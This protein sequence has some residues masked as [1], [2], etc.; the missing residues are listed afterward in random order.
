MQVEIPAPTKPIDGM[1]MKFKTRLTAKPIPSEIK[2]NNFYY[3][4][5]DKL[6]KMKP[7]N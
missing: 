4:Q 6:N 2:N 1:S 5:M 3:L 7:M